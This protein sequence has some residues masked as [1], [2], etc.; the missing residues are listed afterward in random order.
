MK[1][2]ICFVLLV[3]LLLTVCSCK[4]A[5]NDNVSSSEDAVL[6]GE[7]SSL[8]DAVSSEDLSSEDISSEDLSSS[9]DADSSE[10]TSSADEPLS[11]FEDYLLGKTEGNVYTSTSIG[12]TFEKEEEWVY[13]SDEQI[14]QINNIA[15]DMIGD[16]LAEMLRNAPII[17][18]MVVVDGNNNMS[19]LLGKV[20]SDRLKEMDIAEFFEEAAPASKSACEAMG[21]KNLAHEII[22]IDVD[23]VTL[24][25]LLITGEIRGMPM[26]QT[27]FVKKCVGYLAT[28]TV[29]VFSENTTSDWL[30]N[31]TW[32]EQTSPPIV[33]LSCTPQ[34]GRFQAPIEAA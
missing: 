33:P 3:L 11:F 5:N 10:D 30:D 18:D 20:D 23:G 16:E 19:V 12:M 24:D 22:K 27:S 8:E 1:K 32:L 14:K 26:Y 21:Y 15:M 9:E 13:Y 31:F 34:K 17:Y 25:A 29:T 28:V 7:E 4:K 2:T 6:S